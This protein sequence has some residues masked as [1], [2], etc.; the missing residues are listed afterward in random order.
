MTRNE[1]AEACV[2]TSPLP[3]EKSGEDFSWGRGDV[4]TQA[5]EDD[6]IKGNECS[7]ESVA[8]V[9]PDWFS[10]VRIELNLLHTSELTSATRFLHV[11]RSSLWV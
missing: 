9:D 10:F 6:D 1:E 3:Q 4:C 2:Q 7:S 8:G 11:S 5:K